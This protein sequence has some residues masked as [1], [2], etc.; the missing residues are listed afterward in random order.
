MFN[1]TGFHA[2]V[3]NR[4][5]TFRTRTFQLKILK[6]SSSMNFKTRLNSSWPRFTSTQCW[7]VWG[8]CWGWGYE[9]TWG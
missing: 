6:N 2:T 7:V 5:V 9:G 8:G 3:H 1:E 4:F